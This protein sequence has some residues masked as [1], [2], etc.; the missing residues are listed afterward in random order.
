MVEDYQKNPDIFAFLLSTRAGGLGVNLTAADTVT[1]SPKWQAID[2]L[3][4]LC[5]KV[6]M[7]YK[8]AGTAISRTI[9]FL[10]LSV[11]SSLI[12]IIK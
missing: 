7:L 10:Y 3:I 4:K 5:A 1:V 2:K 12:S 8:T 6:A 11:T 9:L